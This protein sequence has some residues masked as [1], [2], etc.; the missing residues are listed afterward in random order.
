M[1]GLDDKVSEFKAKL[2]KIWMDVTTASATA[3]GRA[4]TIPL[5]R[6]FGGLGLGSNLTAGV[7]NLAPAA[8]TQAT[9]KSRFKAMED[10]LV[11]LKFGTKS[12]SVSG[13]EFESKAAVAA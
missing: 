3:G 2:S 13:Q 12:V 7:N 9:L 6:A 4:V 5:Q 8:G 1:K 11:A 10:E